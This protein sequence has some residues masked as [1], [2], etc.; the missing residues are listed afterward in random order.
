[1]KAS[2]FERAAC[3]VKRSLAAKEMCACVRCFD[4]GLDFIK[5]AV[6]GNRKTVVM[7]HLV[8]RSN[9][10][11]VQNHL[12]FFFVIVEF[13]SDVALQIHSFYFSHSRVN[14]SSF[15]MSSV[16]VSVFEKAH[17]R[18]GQFVLTVGR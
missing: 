4:T 2:V 9:T 17:P 3:E 14:T 10:K 12:S 5:K 1:M 13:K 18:L 15:N 7:S 8:D 11:P 6:I 16:C